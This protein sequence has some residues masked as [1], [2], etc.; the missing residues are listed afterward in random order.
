M[1]L[2]PSGDGVFYYVNSTYIAFEYVAH[3]TYDDTVRFQYTLEYSTLAPTVFTFKYW[4]VADSG[5]SATVGIQGGQTGPSAQYSYD[6]SLVPAG[7]MVVCDTSLNSGKGACS[8]SSFNV[9]P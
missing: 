7:T 9:G 5:N 3:A 8:S 4:L 1:S 2:S 6:Q